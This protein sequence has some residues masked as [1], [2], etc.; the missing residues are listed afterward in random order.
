MDPAIEVV[1][2]ADGAG[3]TGACNS[4]LAVADSQYIALVNDDALVEPGWAE[5]LISILE[6]D[7]RCAA[8]QGTNL[9]LADTSTVDGCGIAWNRHWQAIQLDH[10]A[11][12][13]SSTGSPREIFGVS[14]TAAVFRREALDTAALEGNQYL[15]TSLG[16]YYE[17]VD[18]ACRLRSHGFVAVH[19]P[20][21]QTRHAGG[22]S[23]SNHQRW[24]WS[25]IY[26]NRLLVLARLWGR[27]F[28]SRLP[29]L[30]A[31]DLVE[32]AK[33]C[34][35]PDFD[36]VRGIVGGWRRAGSRLSAFAHRGDSLLSMPDLRRFQVSQHRGNG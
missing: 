28:P 17:D 2:V 19:V 16:T 18:L 24:R 7:P 3:F 12:P 36:L 34:A 32:L 31:H 21:A 8:A 9:Q 6:V 35:E 25:Q 23:S 14:G 20:G 29:R 30:L 10:G 1:H 22:V 15:D 13:P 26:G 33:A 5:A 11:R 4:A 27:S